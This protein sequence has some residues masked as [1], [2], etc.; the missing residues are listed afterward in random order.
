MRGI[1]AHV[2]IQ[3]FGLNDNTVCVHAWLGW[4]L[5]AVLISDSLG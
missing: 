5:E 4:H 2:L 3:R 1:T